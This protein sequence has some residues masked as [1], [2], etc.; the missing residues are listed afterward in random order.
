MTNWISTLI[1]NYLLG[2]YLVFTAAL[3]PTQPPDLH[4]IYS[5]D[6]LGELKPCGCSETGNLGGILRRATVYEELKKKHPDAVF[7]SA[8][9]ILGAA[10][11]QGH[12]KAEYMLEGHAHLNLD[13]LLPGEKDLAFPI[14]RLTSNDLPWVLTNK[15]T[16]LTFAAYRYRHLSSGQRV[17]ILGLLE[18]GLPGIPK[19]WLSDPD[20]ALD[21]ALADTQAVAAD[22]VILLLHGEQGFAQ[23][24]S[25][26]PLIDVI[27]RGHLDRPVSSTTQVTQVPPT[28]SAGHRGQHIGMARLQATAVSKLLENQVIPL[29]TSIKDHKKLSHLYDRYNEA[30]SLWYKNKAAQMKSKDKAT[31]PYATASTCKGC[32]EKIYTLWQKTS[33]ALAIKSLQKDSKDHDPECLVCHTTGMGLPGGFVSTDITPAL[34]NIQCEACHGAARKHAEYPLRYKLEPSIGHCNSCHTQEASPD[35]KLSRYYPRIVHKSPHPSPI[36]K[37]SVSPLIGLYDVLEP[38]KTIIGSEPIQLTEFFNFYCSRCYIFSTNWPDMIKSLVKP[39]QHQQIPII[40]G[41]HQQAWSALAYLVAVEH[42]IGEKMKNALFA[43]RFEKGVDISDKQA[44]VS[45]A[46]QLGIG[47]QV[48]NILENNNTE[49]DKKFKQ[50]MDLK[51]HYDIHV[52]PTIMINTNLR[53]NPSHAGDNTNLMLENLQDILLDIQ[54]RQNIHC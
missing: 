46:S 14:E 11:E 36:H 4:L 50:G 37:Q 40:I 25:Q 42:G 23:R 34:E 43:A 22:I 49:I 10:D 31:N 24:F 30:I 17:I 15:T 29:T 3:A 48:K 12:I 35:F 32:H 16:P 19:S 8:G 47:S 27:V 18:P 13:A 21:Q 52:T 9:D 6:F 38:D 2:L 1:A 20:R 28:L 45:I 44:V 41:E 7:V 51:R 53:V 33:H 54:C 39:I 5:S 26:R